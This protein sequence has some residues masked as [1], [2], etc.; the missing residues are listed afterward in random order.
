M[1]RFP[2][3]RRYFADE[4]TAR[5]AIDQFLAGDDPVS[6]RDMDDLRIARRM[7]AGA[8]LLEAVRYYID[9]AG[10]ASDRMISELI[11]EWVKEE[12]AEWRPKYI[13]TIRTMVTLVKRE[14]DGK[15]LSSLNRDAVRRMVHSSSSAHQ[16]WDTFVRFRSFLNWCK[17]NRL[18]RELDLPAIKKPAGDGD[19]HFTK[20]VDVQRLLRLAMETHE[21]AIVPVAIQLFTGIRTAEVMRLDWSSVNISEQMIRVA[22]SV[23]KTSAVRVVD[24]WPENLL[25]WLMLA[26]RSGRVA[27]SGYLKTKVR[28][29]DEAR[30]MGIDVQQ[31]D[32]R[33]NYATYGVAFFQSAGRIAL[34]M[35]HRK[36]D[37]LFTH[38]RGFASKAEAET[39]F[40]LT[41]E[42][43]TTATETWWN[44]TG[45]PA[46]IGRYAKKTA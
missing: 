44:L 1:V 8:D 19:I 34:Q 31:N 15:A 13:E 17:R 2:E 20:L 22:A 11:D 33:H 14:F 46:S 24:W 26:K 39:Y 12:T 21:S 30:R 5:N 40:A 7:L 29:Q 6:K 38:Y 28:L 9:H 32:M 23:A 4:E 16:R 18:L 10:T 41:P 35:G 3:G 37:T 43:V 42:G 25:P 36:A 45:H 27:P